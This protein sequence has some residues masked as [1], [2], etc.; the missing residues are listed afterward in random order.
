MEKE[1]EKKKK[2]PAISPLVSFLWQ[3]YRMGDV[4]QLFGEEE[5]K[6][7]LIQIKNIAYTF[8]NGI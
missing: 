8:E 2:D 7:R 1:K 5:T 6:L 3:C 4:H